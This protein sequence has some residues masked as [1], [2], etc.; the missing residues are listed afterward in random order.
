VRNDWCFL[1]GDF[2]RVY[3]CA[4]REYKRLLYTTEQREK[5]VSGTL[6]EP[7]AE[8]DE[9]NGGAPAP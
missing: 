5:Q 1:R 7:A 2:G 3:V 6:V 9:E 8:P 4:D